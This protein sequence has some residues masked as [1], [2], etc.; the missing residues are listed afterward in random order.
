MNTGIIIPIAYPDAFVRYSEVGFQ[1]HILSSIGVGRNGFV[2]AGHALLLLINKKTGYV[3]YF[4]F[5]RYVTPPGYGRVR[6]AITDVELEIPIK[7]K[8]DTS[9]RLINLKEILIWLE[10]YPE[11]THGE[12]K[13]V[14]SISDNIDYDK[15]HNYLLSLQNQGSIPY[16]TF[17]NIGSNCSRLVT[18]TLLQG[19]TSKTVYNP[20][21]RNNKFTP[22]PLGN[23]KYGATTKIMFEVF[24]GEFKEYRKSILRENLINFFT[25]NSLTSEVVQLPNKIN[26]A[27]LLEGVG[28]S[29]YFEVEYSNNNEYKIKRY[30]SKF[31]KDFEGFFIVDKSGFDIYKDYQFVYDCN[32]NYC[33]IKQEQIIYRFDLI[34]TN[35][36][37][38]V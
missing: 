15:A 11:K 3:Q 33:H 20:L 10:A 4:D 14:A 1:K 18:D 37:A 25:P 7:A 35:K 6:S 32:C 21:K 8:F 36:K 34:L 24:K 5:G 17:G 26:E 13:M 27:Q 29:A 22:S 12:G 38:G 28:A 9:F 19:T 30:N 31:E 2:K 16:K 23:V